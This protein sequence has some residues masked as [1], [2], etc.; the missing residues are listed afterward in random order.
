MFVAGPCVVSRSGIRRASAYGFNNNFWDSFGNG[1]ANHVQHLLFNQNL[2]QE[3]ITVAKN[4]FKFSTIMVPSPAIS[5]PIQLMFV[6]QTSLHAFQPGTAQG[7]HAHFEATVEQWVPSDSGGLNP[8]EAPGQWQPVN[9]PAG[10][11]NN[12]SWN[13]S[14][15]GPNQTNTQTQFLNLTLSHVDTFLRIGVYYSELVNSRINPN[16]PDSPEQGSND[17]SKPTWLGPYENPGCL[18]LALTVLINCPE[19][20]QPNLGTD[21]SPDIPQ[22][23]IIPPCDPNTGEGGSANGMCI[24][25]GPSHAAGT[26]VWEYDPQTGQVTELPPS[27]MWIYGPPFRVVVEPTAVLQ[28]KVLPYTLLY[29]PPREKCSQ[30][31]TTTETS[32][33]TYG[34][35]MS[36]GTGTVAGVSYSDESGVGG[37]TPGVKIPGV[38]SIPLPTFSQ[39]NSSTWS[40]A[41]TTVQASSQA[42]GI[43]YVVGSINASGIV[44]NEPY[45]SKGEP[46][47]SADPSSSCYYSQPFWRDDFYLLVHP[48]FN[49]YNFSHC[50][51]GI[52]PPCNDGK[53]ITTSVITDLV[54]VD[55]IPANPDVLQLYQCLAPGS[56]LPLPA[57]PQLDTSGNPVLDGNGNPAYD[58]P[59]AMSRMIAGR[60]SEPTRFWPV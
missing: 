56:S 59:D 49:V 29:A 18:T 10:L 40:S 57:E 42:L 15:S 24:G 36:F 60:Y 41:T 14:S 1:C 17:G 7:D 32:T 48:K 9:D 54:G 20:G 38:T 2:P 55:K 13:V 47:P 22:N 25:A 45:T 27:N 52:V 33:T 51:S 19:T 5:I 37:S 35:T 4:S 21:P 44:V 23:V 53:G 34:F 26:G 43:S 8:P 12:L 16:V 3:P 39:T 30:G 11:L 50:T 6:D 58:K 46:V 28:A 31:F